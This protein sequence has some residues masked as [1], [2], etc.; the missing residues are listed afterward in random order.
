[1]AIIKKPKEDLEKLEP[2]CTAGENV[3]DKATMEM[4]PH[5]LVFINKNSNQGLKEIFSSPIHCNIIH[6]GHNTT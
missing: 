6:N 2:L 5:F 1:M 3:I 4:A